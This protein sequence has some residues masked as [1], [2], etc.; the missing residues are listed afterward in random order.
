[1]VDEIQKA[2]KCLKIENSAG[3][4]NITV[5]QLKHEFSLNN[6]GIDKLLN[7]IS[8]TGKY[9][10][11]MKGIVLVPLL[12]P[13]RKKGLTETSAHHITMHADEDTGDMY[14]KEKHQKIREH[15]PIS[16]TA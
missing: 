2:I 6:K 5:E 15:I 16:Q 12:K 1:M 14:E 10:K 13:W 3:I 8:K 7:S 11:V 4:D 9:Q